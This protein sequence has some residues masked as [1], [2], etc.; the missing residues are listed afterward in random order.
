MSQKKKNI[1]I[2]IGVVQLMLI[3]GIANLPYILENFVPGRYRLHLPDFINNT[4]GK[5]E[6]Q[7][8]LSSIDSDE[9]VAVAAIGLLSDLDLSSEAESEAETKTEDPTPT[10]TPVP[11]IEAADVTQAAETLQPTAIEVPVET[12]TPTPIPPTATP[13]PSPTPL[14]LNHQV[15]G[16][17]NEPQEYNNC[18]PTNL[19]I[20]LRYYGD[21]TTQLEAAAYLKPNPED[22]NVSP[23][24][25]SDYVNEFTNLRSIT[26]S[27]GNQELLRELV[28]SGFPVVIEK[29]YDPISAN[30]SGWYGHY[31]TVFGYD[32]AKE[33]YNTI[34]TFL[35]P[36][37]NK[38][39][40]EAGYTL[41]DG[42]I[43]SFDY[44]AN[45]WQQFNYT[46]YI[47][48][49]PQREAELYAILGD[50]FVLS[51]ENWKSAALRAQKEAEA[52][53]ENA[54]AWFNLGTS[55]TE[56]GKRT[57]VK[58]HYQ[59]AAVAYDQAFTLGLPSRMLWY[60]H[61]PFFAYNETGR[62]QDA[63]DLADR[64]LVDAGGRTIEE[65]WLHKGHTLS[66]MQDFEGALVA[67]NQALRLNEF[68][69]PAQ[70]GKDYMEFVLG[71]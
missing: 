23:W 45:Y 21:S 39:V 2:L 66:Y 14:P 27:N 59:K 28:A 67:Y 38:D 17:V 65:V 36:F 24:Q 58:E 16:L 35:G 33:E 6:E 54:Y 31:L 9:S 62:H 56:L 15:I 25:I 1:I 26:R 70:S 22:R 47:V 53:P 41:E 61:G 48:Y 29:G 13:A 11:I 71:G 3:I 18:G 51:E 52:E 30:S 69:Y 37:T 50:E 7:I 8:R 32:L 44:V 68:F 34:D 49:E 57:K 19:S 4:L 20:M 55:L 10:S 64:T 40:K 63:L 12:N 43:Y 5:R 46:F 60:Q 42:Y